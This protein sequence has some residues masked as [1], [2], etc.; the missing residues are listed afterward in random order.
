MRD[1]TSNNK[2]VSSLRKDTQGQP[3]VYAQMHTQLA[4]DILGYVQELMWCGSCLLMWENLGEMEV[5]RIR[6]GFLY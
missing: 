5:G 4:S 3:L 2:V 1:P 6:L